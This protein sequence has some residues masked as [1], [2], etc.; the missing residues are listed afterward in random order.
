MED[1]FFDPLLNPTKSKKQEPTKPK[2]NVFFNEHAAKPMEKGNKSKILSDSDNSSGEEEEFTTRK[3]KVQKKI[4]PASSSSNLPSAS[5]LVNNNNNNDSKNNSK[6]KPTMVSEASSKKSLNNS[7]SQ[8]TKKDNKSVVIE[9]TPPKILSI[10]KA[11]I[12][13]IGEIER[14]RKEQEKID[15]QKA[16]EE[17]RRDHQ[18]RE[19]EERRKQI[20]KFHEEE[21]L[22]LKQQDEL[23]QQQKEAEELER[24]RTARQEFEENNRK[25]LFASDSYGLGNYWNKNKKGIFDD[26]D[27]IDTA[28]NIRTKTN[29]EDVPKPQ[30]NPQLPKTISSPPIETKK[31]VTASSKSKTTEPVSNLASTL[32]K[33]DPPPLPSKKELPKL[34]PKLPPKTSSSSNNVFMTSSPSSASQSSPISSVLTPVSS[35]I[36]GNSAGRPSITTNKTNQTRKEE[37]EEDIFSDLVKPTFNIDSYIAKNSKTDKKGLFDFE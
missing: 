32:V 20:A 17:V 30:K 11:N 14:R 28:I 5:V 36:S 22:R 23:L 19:E 27:D 7:L 1:T 31:D 29:P 6:N 9:E 33:K 21:A 2:D 37:E 12:A 13:D 25:N 3:I 8:E 10:S 4:V 15:F 24:K 35:S 18:L 16:I 26:N 34:P